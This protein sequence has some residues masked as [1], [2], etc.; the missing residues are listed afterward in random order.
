VTEI[1][2]LDV[3]ARNW[4]ALALRG[5]FA[6]LFG[7]VAFF[8][9]GI[10]LGALILLF[11]AYAAV[12][13]IFAIVAGVRAAERHERWGALVLEGLIGIAAAAVVIAWPALSLIVF[14]Y[15]IAAW[16]IVSGAVLL[17]T[18]IRLRHLHGEWLLAVNG[19]VSILLGV[20]LFL[21]PIAGAIV[22]AW[23]IGAYALIFGIMLIVM[24]FRLRHY[25]DRDQHWVGGSARGI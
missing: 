15:I 4:W 16:A 5:L 20:M 8:F 11:A 3:L 2:M 14:V 1:A 24:A 13:G 10:T 22:L 9:P 21:S 19:I 17:A 12:D 18:A 6:V 25:R 23:W 7:L